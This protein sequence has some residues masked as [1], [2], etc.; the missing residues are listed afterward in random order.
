MSKNWKVRSK[1]LLRLLTIQL[2]QGYQNWIYR[3]IS[4]EN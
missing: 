3:K 1:T 2:K 4:N